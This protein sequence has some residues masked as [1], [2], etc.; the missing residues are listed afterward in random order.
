MSTTPGEEETPE[1]LK[2]EG[3]L[4]KEEEPTICNGKEVTI[5]DEAKVAELV[6]TASEKEFS[7]LVDKRGLVDIQCCQE[8]VAC[9]FTRVP[10]E[11][12]RL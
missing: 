1:S 4:P 3:K 8:E 6:E 9:G 5:M 7:E 2:E 12:I 11:A 10:R